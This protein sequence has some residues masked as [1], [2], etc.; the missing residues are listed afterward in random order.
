MAAADYTGTISGLK[1]DKSAIFPYHIGE[2]VSIGAYVTDRKVVHPGYPDYVSEPLIE[3]TNEVIGRYATFS[4]YG[5]DF[6][7]T[8]H[9]YPDVVAPGC[10]IYAAGNSFQPEEVYQTAEYTGQFK[11]QT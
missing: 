7:D 8:P 6:S 5:R 4:S 11:G 9:S 2:A 10:A 1:V 3:A